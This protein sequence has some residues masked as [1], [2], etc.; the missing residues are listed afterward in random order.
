M[1]LAAPVIVADSAR[2]RL[3]S[4]PLHRLHENHKRIATATLGNP[5]ETWSSQHSTHAGGP[6]E[7]GLNRRP[8]VDQT[9]A[10]H[11]TESRFQRY[12]FRGP[13]ANV[14]DSQARQTQGTAFR[15]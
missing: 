15:T 13:L 7:D 9:L 6:T 14:V 12:R 2:L 1:S 5:V 8:R 3:L 11:A 4:E 10:R